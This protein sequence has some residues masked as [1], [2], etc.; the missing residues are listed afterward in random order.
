M[1]YIK[2]MPG[3]PGIISLLSTYTDTAE[4]LNA[5]TQQILRGKSS[6]TE[7]E[8]ELIAAFVSRENNCKFCMRAHTAVA[9]NLFPADQSA[10]VEKII[11]QADI[12]SLG[13]KMQALLDIAAAVQKGGKHVTQQQIDRARSSGADDRAIHDTVLIAAAFCMFNRYVDGLATWTPDEQ[14]VY[15][16]IGARLAAQGYTGANT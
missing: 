15:D 4:S 14:P 11:Y 8:R 5:F 6:L 16:N 2:L 12:G 13:E 3:V 9:K 10:V 7:A 1:S